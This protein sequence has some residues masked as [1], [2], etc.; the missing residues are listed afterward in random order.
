[1][2]VGLDPKIYKVTIVPIILYLNKISP[3]DKYG[4]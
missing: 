3:K 4:I 1:M 2:S